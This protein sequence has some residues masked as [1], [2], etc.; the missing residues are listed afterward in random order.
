MVLHNRRKR[1]AFFDQQ[2]TIYNTR[3]IAA[4]ETEKAGVPLADDQLVILG[5][6]KNKVQ[7][8]ERRKA[9]GW[10][11]RTK[12]A[13]FSGLAMDM[14]GKDERI[15]VPTEA[16]VLQRIGVSSVGVLEA[17]EGKASLNR[18]G[19]LEGVKPLT[20]SEESQN[21]RNG[22]QLNSSAELNRV[23]A[24]PHGTTTAMHVEKLAEQTAQDVKAQATGWK[25]WLGW[26]GSK[27]D[28][29]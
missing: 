16:E 23:G 26:G 5:R 21:T 10:W 22:P 11:G 27:G 9:L 15:P 12:G 4:I 20:A 2:H 14:G 3:L 13:L 6:E 24:V 28:N 29:P 19:E 1:S 7:E 17:S 25:D 8:E 18:Q